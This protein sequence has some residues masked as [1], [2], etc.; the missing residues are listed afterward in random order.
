MK[1]VLF[2]SIFSFVNFLCFGQNVPKEY[3]DLI[4]KAESLRKSKE[5]LNSAQTY[6]TAFNVQYL[7]SIPTNDIYN[8]AAS[9]ALASYPDSA[10]FQLNRI[11]KIHC[12]NHETIE[13]DPDLIS[14]HHDPRWIALL[15]TINQSKNGS[16]TSHNKSLIA[17]LDGIRADE[18]LSRQQIEAK[19]KEFGPNSKEV[20]AHWN[21]IYQRDSI[22]LDK[23]KFIL[24]NHGWL[25]ADVIGKPGMSTLFLTIQ[26]AD[27]ATQVKYLP[28]MRE[29]VKNGKA[30]GS[31]LALLED[32]LAL[33]QGRRQIYGS[34]VAKDVESQLMYVFPIENPE[35]VD[36]RRAEIGL[37]PM[38][39][40]LSNW[41]MKWDLE[42]YIKDLPALE[43]RLKN[44]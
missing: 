4:Q 41:Q 11:A 44:R 42:Q 29:A 19:E 3:S 27:Q 39:E 15:Q 30:R 14:L 6:S 2:I 17:I 34:Q 10:F 26:R 20:Q 13:T 23:V 37:P 36:S 12:A 43:E 16:E 9:W 38:A 22:N 25:G 8:S 31:S 7:N 35:G 28:M 18:E 5:Y 24:D 32:R 21:L 1:P 33:E 40:Y